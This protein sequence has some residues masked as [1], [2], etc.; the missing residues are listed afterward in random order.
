MIKI[1]IPDIET[2][3]WFKDAIVDRLNFHYRGTPSKLTDCQ[4][5][6]LKNIAREFREYI[7]LKRKE[8]SS[9]ERKG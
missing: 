5:I 2:A 8:G 6:L 1:D 4:L 9:F 7:K 3:E